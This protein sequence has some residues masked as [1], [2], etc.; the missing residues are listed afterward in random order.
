M[1]EGG[2]YELREK[3]PLGVSFTCQHTAALAWAGLDAGPCLGLGAPSLHRALQ[4]LRHSDMMMGVMM[5]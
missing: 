1:A 3:T 2:R 5:G 4:G